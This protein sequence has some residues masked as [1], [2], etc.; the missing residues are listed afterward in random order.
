MRP[1]KFA[2]GATAGPARLR[3]LPTPDQTRLSTHRVGTTAQFHD[4][5][6]RAACRFLRQHPQPPSRNSRSSA[7]TGW[8]ASALSS[9]GLVAL[10]S[11]AS[12][13]KKSAIRSWRKPMRPLS[14]EFC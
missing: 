7:W 13:A 14:P 2:R 1:I 5:A 4:A 10:R 9:V 8:R 3:G 6:W 12:A 11:N